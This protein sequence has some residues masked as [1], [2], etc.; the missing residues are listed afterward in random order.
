M[1]VTII[2]KGR[3][4]AIARRLDTAAERAQQQGVDTDRA[5]EAVREAGHRARAERHG[6]RYFHGIGPGGKSK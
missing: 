4:S 1:P 6:S 5:F 3:K 2:S